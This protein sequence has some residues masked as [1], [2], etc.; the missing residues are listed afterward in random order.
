MKKIQ[1]FSFLLILLFLYGCTQTKIVPEE[2]QTFVNEGLIYSIAPYSNNLHQSLRINELLIYPNLS[3]TFVLRIK[4]TNEFAVHTNIQNTLTLI[5]RE[6]KQQFTPVKN[7]YP[8]LLDTLEK[9][10]YKAFSYSELTNL[11]FRINNLQER[12]SSSVNY[13]LIEEELLQLRDKVLFLE[14]TKRLEIDLEITK[15][16]IENVFTNHA[17]VDKL[18][19]PQA[20]IITLLIFPAIFPLTSKELQVIFITNKGQIISFPFKIILT[21]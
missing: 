8:F 21:N 5:D 1:I 19:Y 9:N 4:N 2:Y 14:K 11:S 6:T 3:T 12:N 10:D 18:V 17:F 20:E 13:A 15:K 7:I 16:E